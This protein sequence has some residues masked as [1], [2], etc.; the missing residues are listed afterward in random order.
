MTSPRPSVGQITVDKLW[1]EKPDLFNKLCATSCPGCGAPAGCFCLTRHGTIA[2]FHAQRH[3]EAN[4]GVNFYSPKTLRR[5]PLDKFIPI[6]GWQQ[7]VT[8]SS[9]P[10]PRTT[11]FR[12]TNPLRVKQLIETSWNEYL[13]DCQMSDTPTSVNEFAQHLLFMV[14]FEAGRQFERNDHA[15]A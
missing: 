2:S 4:T 14:G 1:R 5:W 11:G 8:A 9:E 10:D 3:L 12:E 13:A 7:E 15:R 6:N